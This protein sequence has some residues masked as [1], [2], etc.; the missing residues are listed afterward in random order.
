MCLKERKPSWPNFGT[1]TRRS[2]VLY[3]SGDICSLLGTLYHPIQSFL[4]SRGEAWAPG[5]PGS[6][7][8]NIDLELPQYRQLKSV[9]MSVL[10]GHHFSRVALVSPLPCSRLPL[11]NA[12]CFTYLNTKAQS[13]RANCVPS[14]AL[15]YPS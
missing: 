7:A 9:L 1:Y 15:H 5:L 11:P 8:P 13:G 6:L 3:T 10:N 4:L 12:W 14:R 2:S